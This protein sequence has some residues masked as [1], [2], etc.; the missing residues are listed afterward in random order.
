MDKRMVHVTYVRQLRGG[1][2]WDIAV[3]WVEE[4]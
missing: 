1:I 2:K 4:K 3:R